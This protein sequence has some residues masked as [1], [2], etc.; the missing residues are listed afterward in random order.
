LTEQDC[1][2][3]KNGAMLYYCNLTRKR[4]LFIIDGKTNHYADN[5][6][7]NRSKSF[8]CK[9][10]ESKYPFPTKTFR[11]LN[12]LSEEE[13]IKVEPWFLIVSEEIAKKFWKEYEIYCMDEEFY[14]GLIQDPELQGWEWPYYVISK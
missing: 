8:N 12:K 4:E 7:K 10:W 5:D 11:S 1:R 3:C 9:R 13:L 14:A 6:R 2:N